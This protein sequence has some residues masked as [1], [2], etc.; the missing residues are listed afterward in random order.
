MRDKFPPSPDDPREGDRIRTK[1]DDGSRGIPGR[2]VLRVVTTNVGMGIEPY[3]TVSYILALDVNG[4][5]IRAYDTF[6]SHAKAWELEVVERV[7]AM[8]P[9]RIEAL[10]DA[11][12][13]LDY[14]HLQRAADCDTPREDDVNIPG[15][16]LCK[17]H[18]SAVREMLTQARGEAK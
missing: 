8:T 18:E 17:E 7:V 15:G 16:C 1:R 9:E 6:K 4:G 13:A 12:D 11:A 5:G 2:V 14:Q 3:E 10:E